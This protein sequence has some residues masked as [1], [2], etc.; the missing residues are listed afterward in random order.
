MKQKIFPSV[1]AKNQQELDEM[2]Q[3]LAGLAKELH[4]D[5]ADGKFVPNTSLWFSLKI[6]ST[7]R[8]NVHLMIADPLTWI[9]EYGKKVETI[10][11]HPEAGQ[12]ADTVMRKIKQIKKKVGLA[13][14][15]E[16]TAASI[17]KYL[18]HL[19]YVLILT[20]HPGF[21]GAKYLKYPLKKIPAIKKMNPDVKVIVDGGMNP[22]TAKEAAKAG[23][24]Y[25]V[26][27]SFITKAEKPNERMREMEKSFSE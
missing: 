22:E 11:F 13:L 2:L 6:P 8:Y 18:P 3:R 1:M 10:I 21:Y 12:D 24:D 17:K 7:F 27:G 5:V 19:D 20:V 25:I 9:K 23:A 16:T 14:K 26:S 15:P 4:L